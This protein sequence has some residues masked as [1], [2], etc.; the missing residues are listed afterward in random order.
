M[1]NIS[2]K[3]KCGAVEGTVSHA[4]PKEGNYLVCYCED[5]QAFANHLSV[6][7][8][9]LDEW[10]GTEIYQIAPWNI[11]I[12]KGFE[13]LKC[14][15]LAPKGLYRWYTGCCGTAVGNTVSAK[16]PFFGLM[17]AF[18][19]KDKLTESQLGPIMGYH[20]LESANGEVP[21]AILDKG[22]P[23]SATIAVFWRI[24]KWKVAGANK[25]NPFFDKSGQSSSKP[26]ILTSH[27]DQA[28]G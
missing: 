20:K 17:H 18:I 23:M 4:S 14:L 6:G 5:C 3:C 26:T 21:E 24:F 10:G 25:P 19:D 9:I 28:N 12:D 13:Q 16:I 8:S 2:L 27:S 7:D 22:M 11:S 15:R 1:T